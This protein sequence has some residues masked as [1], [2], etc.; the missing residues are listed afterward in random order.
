MTEEQGVEEAI[1]QIRAALA[2]G[3]AYLC[4]GLCDSAVAAYPC[5]AE[6]WALRT[7]MLLWQDRHDDAVASLGKARALAP[8]AALT[9]AA[10]AAIL[11]FD[12]DADKACEVAAKA[13]E[14][15]NN[16]PVVLLRA[17]DAF[18]GAQMF[19]RAIEV[20]QL[21]R[22]LWPENEQIAAHGVNVLIAASRNED[23]ARLLTHMERCFPN[24]PLVWRTRAMMLM[25]ENRLREAADL[26]SRASR[27]LP[28]SYSIWAN[29]ALA[30]SHLQQFDEAE[31]AAK[32]SLKIS[33]CSIVAMKA[34]ARVCR[35]RGDSAQ[36]E[37]WRQ[38]SSKA[39]PALRMN[40]V[41][42]EATG[43]V[44][45]GDWV[46][47]LSVIESGLADMPRLFR[48]NGLSIK[49]RALLELNSRRL[50][51]AQPNKEPKNLHGWRGQE[52]PELLKRDLLTEAEQV[53]EELIRYG[54]N[55][56][57][58]F[59]LRARASRQRGR[60]DEAIA[61]LHDGLSQHPSSG[62]LAAS[63]IRALD[64]AGRKADAEALINFSLRN[65]PQAP[66]EYVSLMMAMDK[67]GHQFEAREM[68][69]AGEERFPNAE[70]FKVFAAVDLLRVGDAEGARRI[71]GQIKGDM[72]NAADA[73]DRSASAL[74]RM[75]Q[76]VEN[77]RTRKKKSDDKPPTLN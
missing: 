57:D 42:S 61:I 9:L 15:D 28:G 53:L 22:D 7:P 5:S 34:M 3:D 23:A 47:A 77:V 51:V 11:A 64:F 74:D 37:Q 65:P 20:S 40:A 38:R 45:G 1:A 69:R 76:I 2:K 68:R 33:P 14:V 30:L 35:S 19:D 24:S 41:L 26:L 29:L 62:V 25:R 4:A 32:R 75:R 59:D 63:L 54:C 70:A 73:L 18:A 8:D 56:I 31:A 46:K 39:I 17:T 6:V 72:R 12:G 27:V 67:T 71:T 58:I 66:F 36:A 60:V 50:H 13:A 55:S 10:E 43:A 21:A 44:R 49:A 48:L 52:S 16:D